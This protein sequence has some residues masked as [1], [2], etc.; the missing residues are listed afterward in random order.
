M[1][2]LLLANW[3]GI[4]FHLQIFN[5]CSYCWKF[6]T[7]TQSPPSTKNTVITKPQLQQNLWNFTLTIHGIIPYAD[8][9]YI[10]EYL[11]TQRTQLLPCNNQDTVSMIIEAFTLQY[12]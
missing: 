7:K 5:N 4:S 8:F 6:K 9:V 10:N 2:Y 3:L 12:L 1:L 11:V